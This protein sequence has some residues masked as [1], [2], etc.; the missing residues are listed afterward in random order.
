[1]IYEIKSCFRLFFISF[2]FF[3]GSGIL[4]FLIFRDQVGHVKFGF[5]ELHFVHAFS[6][7][8]VEESFS[9]EYTFQLFSDSIEHFLIA[10][11]L[12]KKVTAIFKLLGGCHKW[13]ILCCWGSIRRI[14]MSFCLRRSKFIRQPLWWIFFL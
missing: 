12:P 9:S 4:I 3:L 5:S 13:M 14:R 10:V 7:K 8:P 2:V 11:E 6:R 1:M